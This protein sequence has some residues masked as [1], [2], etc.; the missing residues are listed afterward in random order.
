MPSA[1]MWRCSSHRALFTIPGRSHCRYCP[2]ASNVTKTIINEIIGKDF[3]FLPRF[4]FESA[5]LQLDFSL[6]K[7]RPSKSRTS[8]RKLPRPPIL[9]YFEQAFPPS[10]TH[11][12]HLIRCSWVICDHHG[13]H[14]SFTG[15]F[16]SHRGFPQ[17]RSPA[18]QLP[19]STR[20]TTIQ[21]RQTP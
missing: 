11:L 18:I 20:T 15:G 7:Q 12:L 2:P 10:P 17:N 14:D 3:L 4:E 13:S 1:V 16:P 9:Q 21:E 19:T 6:L 8:S 5:S